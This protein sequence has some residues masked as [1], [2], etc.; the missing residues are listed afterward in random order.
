MNPSVYALKNNK[1]LFSN[2][3]GIIRLVKE[4]DTYEVNYRTD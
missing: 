1:T 4:G 3:C 2:V